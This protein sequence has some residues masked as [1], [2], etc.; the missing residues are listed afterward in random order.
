MSVIN[1][2]DE[3]LL[4]SDEGKTQLRMNLSKY[5]VFEGRVC[6]LYVYLID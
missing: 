2:M 6:Y 4:L 3:N 1:E 5:E